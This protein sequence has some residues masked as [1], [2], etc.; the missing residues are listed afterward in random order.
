[1]RVYEFSKQYNIPAKDVITTLRA[2][3]FDIKSHM[4]IIDEKAMVFLKKKIKSHDKPH[5]KSEKS[6]TIKQINEKPVS[7]VSSAKK[8]I[9]AGD[10]KT[11][12]QK[13][14][15]GTVILKEMSVAD[16]AHKTGIPVSDIILTLLKA[17]V[18]SSKNKAL[19]EDVVR[20]LA[21]HYELEVVAPQ[22]SQEVE[23]L[24]EAP[25]DVALNE[26]L[27]VVVV[28]GHVDHGKTTL[29]DFIRKTR[30]ASREKGGITQHIGAYEAI[31]N[32]GNIVF[33]D[34]PG[35]E[36]FSKI[37]KRG[38]R[39]ADIVILIVA[40]DDGVKPQTVEAIRHAL[41]MKVPI[42]VA[43]NKMD[44]VDPARVDVVKR[45][46]SQHGVVPEEWGGTAICI[47][48][49]A[50][51]GAGIDGLLEM[52][53]LQAQLME[54]RAA[55]EGFARGFVLESSLEKGYGQVATII[56]QHG[57]VHVGDFFI[58]G[59]TVGKVS[60]ITDSH[61][62]RLKDA[63]PSIPVRISGFE[64]L[65]K[66]G[67]YFECVSKSDY[68]ARR[69][70]VDDRQSFEYHGDKKEGALKF[71]I[72]T[73]TNS[74]KEALLDSVATL[75]RKT[76]KGISVLLAGVGGV[77]ESDVELAYNTGA[78]IIGLHVKV[79]PNAILLAQQRGVSI[80][81]FDI[82]YKLLESFEV[83]A[84][85]TATTKKVYTRVGEANVLR[86]FDIKGV[87]VIAGSYVKEGRFAVGGRVNILRGN[88]KI[89]EGVIK[90]LQRD[91]KSVKEVHTGFECGF[92]VEGFSDWLPDDVVE[93]LLELPAK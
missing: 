74:S 64:S 26:R 66:A 57:V 19:P 24:G 81:R 65:P 17:G 22:L 86:V 63:G 84:K 93:C 25:K 55:H 16:F 38:V 21:K 10:K 39:V 60:T 52:I 5:D 71:V 15:A 45:E 80:H 31:T 46:L 54:L 72:K 76:D 75:S 92:V 69:G 59:N 30:V 36:A 7:V 28:L 9:S 3:G 23:R 51:T 4:S 2:E 20:S 49:S 43:I 79:E 18:V 87:G 50:K 29:L 56:S 13:V 47:P 41:A 34:T 78:S 48:I 70:M 53:A 67:D 32:H 83:W 11:V 61:A 91:K 44:K 8:E 14:D 77:T 37:R 35:H 27:P 90:S 33:L 68:L 12:D 62:K 88:K 58:A 1:M 89:G 82:I 42:I 40:A 6:D 73:D 85:K